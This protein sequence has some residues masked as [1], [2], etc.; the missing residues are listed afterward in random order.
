MNLRKYNAGRLALLTLIMTSILPSTACSQGGN[1]NM[2]SNPD[3]LYAAFNTSKGEILVQLEFKKTP[4][5]VINFVGLAEGSLQ[6]NTSRK[7]IP[8]F[9]GL[10]FHR[11]IKDFMVQGGD[12][13]GS[14]R[15]G[16]GYRF[17]DEFDPSLSHSGPGVLS[18]ANSGPGSNGSQFFITHVATP[19]LD[20]KHTVFGKVVKGQEIVNAIQQNDTIVKL[21]IIRK[22]AE[23][24]AFKA[25]QAAWDAALA[26]IADK[27]KA[28][29]GQVLK[30]NQA[31]IE[32]LLPN[33]QKTP[34]GILYLI[35][36]QGSGVKPK[37]GQTVS[38][39]YTGKLL[40]GT[41]F[42][43]SVP[44][45][46]PLEVPIGVG[47]LIPGWDEVVLLMNVGEKRRIILP[48]ELAY[49]EAGAGGVIPGNAWLY[50]E[51]ELLAIK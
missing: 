2:A 3:G 31:K 44:R 15:G 13:E 50:F 19:W 25:D 17:P 23:A 48:P 29:Q 16:P 45:K 49:G 27:S 34:S 9:D 7:G 12:P 37:S 35:D 10:I 26:G 41:T 24:E 8:F 36:R 22:G 32:A 1:R 40:D 43:S 30:A 14:G 39:H 11:V 6:K 21:E 5:T 38:V 4:L 28:T 20:G 47:N 18:M 42:D 51:L 46:T 33:P